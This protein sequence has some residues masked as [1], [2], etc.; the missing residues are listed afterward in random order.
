MRFDVVTLFGP[1]FDAV[2]QH[3][4]SRRAVERGIVELHCWNPRDF[5]CDN[6]RTVDDRP[7]GGGP[8]MVMLAEPLERAIQSARLAQRDVGVA[9]PKVIY[10]SP[11]GRMLDHRLVMQLAGEPGLILLAGRYEG[12][13]ERVIERQVDMEISIGDYVL[14]GG[15]LGAMVLIDAVVR[16]LPGVLNDAGSAEQDSFVDGLLDCP[17]YTRPEVYEESRVPDVLLSGNHAEINR[18]RLKQA[19]GRTWLRRPELLAKR[20][21]TKEESRLLAQFQKEQDSAETE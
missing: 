6:Y 15:E 11:Q 4:V 5:A 18:W 8:G 2:T 1:M 3:G 14:S 20:Q 13:D 12:V 9:S 21:L 10:L 19:L 16:Q 7:Y 17:H